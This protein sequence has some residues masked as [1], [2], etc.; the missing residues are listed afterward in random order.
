M[1]RSLLKLIVVLLVL[2]AVPAM[3]QGNL[4]A[5]CRGGQVFLTWAERPEAREY[6]ISRVEGDRL[7][8]VGRAAQGSGAD[9]IAQR[10]AERQNRK[11]E[12]RGF[13]IEP[14]GE[15]LPAETGLWVHT[16]TERAKVTYRVASADGVEI[17][18]ATL[19]VR[20]G[21]PQP[22]LESEK[23]V[24]ENRTIRTYLHWATPEMS[25]TDGH[26]FKFLVQ[27]DNGGDPKAKLPMSVIL[28]GW[29]GGYGP[30]GWSGKPGIWLMP[31]DF[32]RGLAYD[33]YDWWYGYSDHFADLP[34]S[35]IRNFTERRLLFTIDWVMKRYPVDENRVYLR[36]SSMGGTGAIS[37]GMRHPEL[38]AAIDTNV[39]M[40][41][42]GMDGIG[43]IQQGL[44]KNWGTRAQGIKTNEG[45]PVWER[46]NMVRFMAEHHGDL[47]F[48]KTISGRG[49]AI[50]LWPQIPPFYQALQGNRHGFAAFWGPEGHVYTHDPELVPPEFLRFDI[51]RFR[52]NES[53]PAISRLSANA[54]P[55][56]GDP[57]EGD[58]I[59]FLNAGFDWSDIVDTPTRWEITLTPVDPSVKTATLDLT[60]RRLQKLVVKAG[61]TYRFRNT[62]TTGK[63]L[64]EGTIRP[65]RWGLLTIE[66]L[67]VAPGGNRVTIERK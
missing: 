35:T 51:E 27:V 13:V 59:G 16:A 37:F 17:G 14:Q 22:I 42:P 52:K 19:E 57:K 31:D 34:H 5:F 50:I 49:D 61:S 33:I 54:N 56:H 6:V 64:Q 23:R 21:A 12:P 3:A 29:G 11:E 4:R 15:P 36:G 24:G 2:L 1:R 63:L 62:D 32:T 65:D 48:L 38:F 10:A 60:P 25:G 9:F 53:Y 44:E 66:G 30:T 39:P 18:R 46:Q 41:N 67:Q 55:G 45:I 8:E 43:P 47:P 7:V 20:P 26:P 28:H 58:P 40:V